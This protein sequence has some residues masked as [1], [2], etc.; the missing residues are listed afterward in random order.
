MKKLLPNIF[1]V[2]SI[3]LSANANAQFWSKPK[4]E[5]PCNVYWNGREFKL[6]STKGNSEF[7]RFSYSYYGVEAVIVSLPIAMINELKIK[8]KVGDDIPMEGKFK[9]FVDSHWSDISKL[10]KLEKIK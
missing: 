6:G 4:V 2:I 1:L 10:C 3:F 8:G 9:K 7:G 5:E